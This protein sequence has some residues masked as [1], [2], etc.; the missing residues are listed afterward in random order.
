MP[1]V[2]TTISRD[3]IGVLI[4]EEGHVKNRIERD[5]RVTLNVDS[6][7]GVVAIQAQAEDV[8]PLAIL[9]AKDVVAAIARGFPPEKAF[10]LFDE[11][12][13]LDVLNLRELFGK[14]D[15]D[16]QRVKGRIIGRDGKARRIVEEITQADLSIHGHTI[17]IIGNYDAA[18]LAREGLEML[19]KGR[20]HATV[21]Q[22][23][24][25]KRRA[26]KRKEKVELWEKPPEGA[27]R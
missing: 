9:R 18:S 17:G 16:I 3:R 19:I 2:T 25:N 13:M 24:R 20:Q 4:G 14:S 7:S 23:L 26:I 15:S 6:D 10:R 5:L 1:E 8:N 22:Y 12:M 27:K 11:E 21:Y